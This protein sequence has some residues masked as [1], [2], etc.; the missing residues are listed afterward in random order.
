MS[1]WTVPVIALLY[2]GLAF[3]LLKPETFSF[4]IILEQIKYILRLIK[5]KKTCPKPEISEHPCPVT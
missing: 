4:S 3:V 5:G 2:F 1:N